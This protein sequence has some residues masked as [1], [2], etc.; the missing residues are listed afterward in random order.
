MTTFHHFCEVTA[1][2]G[3]PGRGRRMVTF[4][5]KV[6]V[7]ILYSFID[8]Q[9]WAPTRPIVLTLLVL[10]FAVLSRLNFPFEEF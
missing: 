6:S 2:Q 9:K 5:A 3:Q 7:N 4:L 10:F 1:Y 8:I